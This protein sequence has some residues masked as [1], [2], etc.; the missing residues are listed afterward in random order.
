MLT[1]RP[2][3]RSELGNRDEIFKQMARKIIDLRNRN[4]KGKPVHK[5]VTW[6]QIT[7]ERQVVVNGVTT[8]TIES[9]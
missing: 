6:I 2:T 4:K 3:R 1:T 8:A 7:Y 5:A 9:W